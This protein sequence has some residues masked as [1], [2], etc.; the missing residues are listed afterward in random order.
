MFFL[1]GR[2]RARVGAALALLVWAQAATAQQVLCHY[3][4]GGETRTLAASPVSSPYAVKAIDVGSYFHF[5]VVFQDRPA[6]LASVKIYTYADRNDGPL[7]VHQASYAYPPVVGRD[8]HGTPGTP[9]GFTGWQSVY[10]PV[11]DGELQY[12]CEVSPAA[13]DA[14]AAASRRGDSHGA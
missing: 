8:G 12:W 9:G 13:R 6:D 4:Y 7:L 2:R 10:E 3:S 14:Q 5:R 11:R 1:H